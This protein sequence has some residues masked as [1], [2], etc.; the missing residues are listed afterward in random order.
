MLVLSR[1]KD[2]STT[3]GD[4]IEVTIVAIHGRNVRLGVNAPKD[5]PV[6]RKEVYREI[7][8]EKRAG[9]SRRE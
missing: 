2:E 7:Q 3:I 5:V 1:R 9:D 8:R 6:H 4:D